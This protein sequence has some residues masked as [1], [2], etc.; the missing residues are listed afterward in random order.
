MGKITNGE[1][2]TQSSRETAVTPQKPMQQPAPLDLRRGG[3][4]PPNYDPNQHGEI[5]AIPHNAYPADGMTM[6]CR[7]GPPSERSSGTNS[8]YRPSSRDSQS[9]LSN[10]TSASS[11]EPVSTKHSPTKPTNGV[12]LP[13]INGGD[14]QVQK[15]KSAFFSNSP[16]RRKSRHDKERN[17][18]PSQPPARSGWDSPTKQPSPNKALPQMQQP[19]PPQPQAQPPPPQ[20]QFQMQPQA[21]PPAVMPPPGNDRAPSP[22]P[23]DPRANFQLNVGNNVFDVASPDKKG[24]RGS[25]SNQ[26]GENDLDPIA[27]ALADL[28]TSGKPAGT[29]VSAD[30]YHG[31]ATPAPPSNAGA[32]PPPAYND[33]SVKRLDAPQPAFTSAQMQKTTQKYVNQPQ[34]AMRRSGNSPGPMT[35]NS[36]PPPQDPQR[37]RSPTPRRSASPNVSP[38]VD[39]RMTQYT[40]GTSPSPSAYQ[41]S[42]MRGRF[43]QS[44]TVSTPPQRPSDAAYSP[45]EYTP[46][47]P[48]TMGRAVSPQPQ[49]RQQSRP[50]SSSAGGME[51]Q[52][53]GPQGDMYGGG[54]RDSY[55]QR[56]RD[57]ARPISY[58]GDAGSQGSRSRSRTMAVADPGRQ[59]S[60]DGRPI[61]HFSKC[62]CP[63]SVFFIIYTSLLIIHL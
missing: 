39:T 25:Q 40:R 48:N 19:P 17:S 30:R 33:S 47:S 8:G 37:A 34:S 52:L 7:T 44:P 57:P 1:P 20:P 5:A 46:R 50:S 4:L 6:F 56:G 13:G 51:L 36:G 45:R 58:Y 38:R 61:L 32:V 35:R 42:S 9:D 63:F 43:S 53:S 3:Q 55:S 26:G 22:E 62:K 27:R 54:G 10:P 14:T 24:K 41:S 29:R 59:I 16:F 60:R 28:K 49:Y 23:V 2:P 12:A 21:Q 18:G 31:L 11:Q 15:K